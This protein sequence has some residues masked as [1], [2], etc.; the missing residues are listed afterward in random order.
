MN[1]LDKCSICNSEDDDMVHG[2]FGML[3]VAFC[4]WCREGVES[5]CEYIRT[6]E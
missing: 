5:Y 3:P 6:Y 1:E 2:L 4:V